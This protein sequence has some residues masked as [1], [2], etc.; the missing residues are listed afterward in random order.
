MIRN[1][2]DHNT[3]I[4]ICS[5]LTN[6]VHT[7]DSIKEMINSDITYSTDFLWQVYMKYKYEVIKLI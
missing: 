1:K 6:K 3:R 4:T 2:Q 7:R 5:L